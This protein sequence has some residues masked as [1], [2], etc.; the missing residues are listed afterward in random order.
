[1]RELVV[2]LRDAPD[3]DTAAAAL[4]RIGELEDTV[5]AADAALRTARAAARAAE[6]TASAVEREVATAWAELRAARDPLVALDAPALGDDLVDAWAELVVWARSAAEDRAAQAHRAT[7]SRASVAARRSAV[8]R[9]V[10]DDLA[11]HDVP[12]AAAEAEVVSG[13]AA[14]AVATALERAR[15]AHARV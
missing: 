12:L 13:A 4:T 2:A 6:D 9:R 7:R 3:D 15:G 11:A 14:T 1:D 5:R 10:L 8:V